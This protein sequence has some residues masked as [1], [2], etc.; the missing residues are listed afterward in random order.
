MA[1][2]ILN[3][4]EDLREDGQGFPPVSAVVGGHVLPQNLGFCAQHST[5]LAWALFWVAWCEAYSHLHLWVYPAIARHRHF[6]VCFCGYGWFN[7]TA[8]IGHV[9]PMFAIVYGWFMADVCHSLW[10]VYG[11]CLQGVMF[12]ELW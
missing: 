11:R 10:L 9:W 6:A 12:G 8:N 4:S 3:T 2:Q 5:K 7:S 1:P